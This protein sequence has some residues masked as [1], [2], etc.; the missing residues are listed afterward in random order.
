MKEMICPNCQRKQK[1]QPGEYHYTESGL[2]NVWLIGVEIFECECG[3]SFAF[4]PCIQ[5]LHKLIAHEL[6]TQEN[7]LSGLEIRF[8]RKTMGLKAKDFAELLGV[9]NVSVSRWEHGEFSPPE[10]TDRFIRLFYAANMGLSEI[11]QELAKNIFRKPKRKQ[12]QII[13]LPID[14]LSR[15]TCMNV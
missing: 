9:K 2:P 13:R 4:I 15:E 1:I 11:A 14:R 6:I 7:S 8:L 12:A 3:E 10:P 5:E